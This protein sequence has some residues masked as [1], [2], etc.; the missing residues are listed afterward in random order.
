MFEGLVA[1]QAPVDVHRELSKTRRAYFTFLREEGCNI[2]RPYLQ[3][4]VDEGERL[5]TD[6]PV[7]RCTPGWEKGG[8]RVGAR[9]FGSPFLVTRHLSREVRRAFRPGFNPDGLRQGDE[10]SKAAL[11]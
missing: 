1:G 7:I 4:R 3:S 11:W 9:N 10:T 6:S 5:Q 2:L 8:K